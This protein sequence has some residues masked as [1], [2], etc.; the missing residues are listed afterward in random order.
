MKVYALVGKSGA[1]KS[2]HSTAVAAEYGLE[3]IID[4]GILIS[5]NRI[6]AGK[7]AKRESTRM[8]SVRCAIFQDER[9]AKKMRDAIAET[10]ADSILILGTSEKMVR[11][12]AARL[13][14]PP[15]EKMIYIED[16]S[17]P[18]EIEAAVQTRRRQGTHII[19]VP[20]P[21]ANQQLPEYIIYPL[22]LLQKMKGQMIMEE[23]TVVQPTYSQTG[24]YTISPRAAKDIVRCALSRC[25]EV[26]RVCNVKCRNIQQAWSVEV[27]I[28]MNYP[29][30]VRD[31]AGRISET[32]KT[33]MET[34][35]GMPTEKV[36]V[37]VSE[38][39]IIK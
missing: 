20:V 16:V 11:R 29:C 21:E 35:T 1:G 27:E 10:G 17:S 12:I 13:E 36:N 37:S 23:K 28:C 24:S 39:H 32:V 8:A 26:Y 4:D 30:R 5:K 2:Q 18:E 19:P 9:R 7:S 15:I 6:L 31:C 34:L 22:M 3:Y 25:P 33:E 38:L 14:L